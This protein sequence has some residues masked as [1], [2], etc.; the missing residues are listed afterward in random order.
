MKIVVLRWTGIV[1][2]IVLCAIAAQT[3]SFATG[4]SSGSLGKDKL[5]VSKE[6]PKAY[7]NDNLPSAADTVSVVGTS[8]KEISKDS[9]SLGS[10]EVQS[11]AIRGSDPDN[12]PN[13]PNNTSGE[14]KPGQ[15]PGERE[16]AYAEWSKRIRT[17]RKNVNQ[18]AWEL[19]DLKH[20]PP[21]SV[22]IFH[23]WPDDQLYLQSIT[24]KQ[25]ALDGARAALSDL[26]DQ[27]RRSGVPSS[28]IDG[29]ENGG[30][31]ES[32]GESQKTYDEVIVQQQIRKA[33]ASH[34]NESDTNGKSAVQNSA[35]SLSGINGNPNQNDKTN[36]EIKPGQSPEDRKKAYVYWHKQIQQREDRIDQLTRELD[37]LKKNVPTAVI[38]HLWPED[39]KYLQILA[40]K[41]KAVEQAKADFSDFQEQ[42]RKLGV[43]SSFREER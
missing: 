37:D 36:G 4:E 8:A 41:Q 6:A 17:E 40:D 25:K 26:E 1:S 33:R 15:S 31:P 38:M 19:D 16:Q 35:L 30:A 9:N 24:E 42:A 18:L 43:P 11:T 12:S 3:Q 7:D 13:R 20:N 10:N 5:R 22:A 2:A 23:L 27:A 32:P 39:Q 29:G 14:I 28:L 34:E 21:A